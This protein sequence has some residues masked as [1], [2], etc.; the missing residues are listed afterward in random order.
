[1]SSLFLVLGGEKIARRKGGYYRPYRRY[2][3]RKFKRYHSRRKGIFSGMTGNLLLGLGAGFV[4]NYIPPVLGRWTIPAVFI[5]GGYVAKKPQLISIGAYE[6]GQAISQQGLNLGGG[7][8]G[9]GS[10]WE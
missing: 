1:M 3:G 4:R 9:N 5:G 2:Y 6:L 10:F 8:N 7:G